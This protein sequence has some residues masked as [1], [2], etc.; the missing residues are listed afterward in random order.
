MHAPFAQVTCWSSGAKVRDCRE[1]F[2]RNMPIRSSEFPCRGNLRD[3]STLRMRFQLPRTS[4]TASCRRNSFCRFSFRSASCAGA[5]K[6]I[7][8][9]RE[10]C[11][12]VPS[13]LQVRP[14]GVATGTFPP[15]HP[16]VGRGCSLDA[17]KLFSRSREQLLV[18]RGRASPGRGRVSR[19]AARRGR[20]GLL[21]WNLGPGAAEVAPLGRRRV[22]GN[23][24]IRAVSAR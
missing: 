22:R 16:A 5:A 18:P 14:A 21:G 12:C 20:F 3:P 23:D 24:A 2:T 1:T 7:G 11:T 8:G 13:E 17:E 10:S 4:A 19:R 9:S 15:A 6:A